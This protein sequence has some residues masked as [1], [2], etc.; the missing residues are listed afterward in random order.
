MTKKTGRPEGRPRIQFDLAGVERLS[1]L[2]CTQSEIAAFFGVSLATVESRLATDP[3]MLAAWERG[4]AT[5]AISLRRKQS[6]MAD[7]GNIT[8]LI[9]LGKQI[10]K[11][12][13][14]IE[15]SG[16][17]GGPMELNVS[18]TELLASRIARIAAHLRTDIGDKRSD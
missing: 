5:G 7:A 12:R 13:D 16:P 2:H 14:K 11:Q 17:E 6:Q 18:G 9:W 4:R 15:H 10:L 3:E 1:V 8:M